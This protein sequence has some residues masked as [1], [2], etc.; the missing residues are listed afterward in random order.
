VPCDER[1]SSDSHIEQDDRTTDQ[2]DP[3]ELRERQRIDAHAQRDQDCDGN[4]EGAD[5]QGPSVHDEHGGWAS[6]FAT[7]SGPFLRK[8]FTPLNPW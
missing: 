8:S 2:P 6:S 1:S 5:E 3:A 4:R 7:S